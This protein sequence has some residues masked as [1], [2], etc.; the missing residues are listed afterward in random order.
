MSIES[1]IREMAQN[2]RL[3]AKEMARCDTARKNDVLHKIAQRLQ[4]RAEEIKIQNQKDLTYG[5][6]KGLSA[7]MIDRLTITD[8]TIAAM[9]QGLNEVAQQAD[10]VGSMGPNSLRPNGLQVARMRIPLGVIGIIYESR[11][12]VTTKQNYCSVHR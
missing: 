12:N 9:I 1:D 5:R 7:A 8:A 2:A 11:P 3:A 4:T 10:P 6:D